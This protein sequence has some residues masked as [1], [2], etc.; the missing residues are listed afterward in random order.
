M[1]VGVEDPGDSG[2]GE[3]AAY[4]SDEEER[5]ATDLVD[6]GDADESGKE[7][8]E[9]DDDSLEVARHGAEASVGEDVVKV[10]EDGVDSG[11]LVEEA[12]GDGQE[13]KFAVAVL[14]EG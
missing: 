6:D 14:E 1:F 7:I 9:A 10:I 3:T 12:D 8:G 5:F 4:G 11:E 2:E 13:D